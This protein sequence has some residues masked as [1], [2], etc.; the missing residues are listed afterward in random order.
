MMFLYIISVFVLF[1]FIHNYVII[2][3]IWNYDNITIKVIKVD[4]NSFLQEN[5]EQKLEQKSG[6]KIWSRNSKSRRIAR[7]M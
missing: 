4:N 5:L 7:N 1:I 2:I 6:A 3:L